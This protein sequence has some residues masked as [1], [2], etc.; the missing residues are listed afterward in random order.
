MSLHYGDAAGA[1][2]NRSDFL[3]N[4]GIDYRSLVCAKQVHGDRVRYVREEDLGNGALTYATAITDTD[5][6]VTD[7]L[8]IPLAIFT[9]DCLSVFL[10][11][12]ETPA[13]GLVHAGWRSTKAGILGKT[14]RMMRDK[15]DTRAQNLIVNF[16]PAIRKCC[17]GVG[18][19]FR[20]YFPVDVIEKSGK[21]Y[22]DLAGINKR[23][24]I[25][26]GVREDN[27]FDPGICTSCRNN[28]FFSF[29]REGKNCGRM[30][31]VM[32][33]KMAKG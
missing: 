16:G 11:D 25:D 26:S 1:L 2:E 3:S 14:I 15:F 10:Y 24:A 27:I 21:F 6:F 22:L 31:S 29:R 12:P 30:I 13:I 17:Y 23:Q 5:A 32:M 33:L 18:K 20:D 4:L 19:E 8:N 28:E 9:A 7:E